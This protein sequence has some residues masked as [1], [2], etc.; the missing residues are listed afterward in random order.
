MQSKLGAPFLLPS[1]EMNT[2]W[3]RRD[4]TPTTQRRERS[5]H[6]SNKEMSIHGSSRQ[7]T[8]ALSPGT[9]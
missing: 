6:D 4:H 3:N 8:K 7:A 5:T 9:H 2:S 1:E